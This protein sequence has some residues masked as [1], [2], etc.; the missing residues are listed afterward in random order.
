MLRSTLRCQA[1]PLTPHPVRIAVPTYESYTSWVLRKIAQGPAPVHHWV[2]QPWRLVQDPKAAPQNL[3]PQTSA[4][5]QK[6]IQS[7][8]GDLMQVPPEQLQ[9]LLACSVT[10]S[11]SVRTT[12]NLDSITTIRAL[13]E[14]FGE[15]AGGFSPS[16][17]SVRLMSPSDVL[18]AGSGHLGALDGFNARDHRRVLGFSAGQETQQLASSLDDRENRRGLDGWHEPQQLAAPSDVQPNRRA[19]GWQERRQLDQEAPKTLPEKQVR[20]LWWKPWFTSWGKCTGQWRV[21]VGASS[22]S[23]AGCMVFG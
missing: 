14:A 11:F 7:S 17:I 3:T 19:L 21:G 9:V 23:L 2:S 20:P 18:E 1:S 22:R 4:L 16:R 5:L 10:V 15:I 13:Q 6:A 8:A 12:L